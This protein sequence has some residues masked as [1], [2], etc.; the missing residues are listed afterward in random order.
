MVRFTLKRID[1]F[2][3]LQLS[4]IDEGGIITVVATDPAGGRHALVTFNEDGTITRCTGVD[5]D[6]GLN[7]TGYDQV[8]RLRS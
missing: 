8:V 6:I 2:R 3:E 1:D 5:P 4:L 7:I